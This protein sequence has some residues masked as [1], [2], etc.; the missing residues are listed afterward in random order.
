MSLRRGMPSRLAVAGALGT[1]AALAATVIA[2][3]A[4]GLTAGPRGDGTGV[5]P[6]GWIVDPA[7]TQVQVGGRPYGL[8]LSPDGGR[9]LLSNDGQGTQSLMAVDTAA[10]SVA[11]TLPYSS[12][13]ALYLGVVYAPDGKRAY[14]SAGGN[15]KVRTYQVAADG[16]LTETAA[17]ALPAGSYPGGLATSADGKRLYVAN[18]LGESLAIVDTATGTVASTTPVGHNP[19][20]VALSKDGTRAYV[21]NWG[22]NTVSAA[23]AV[24]GASLGQVTVGTHP[25]A[26]AVNPVSGELYVANS[27]GDSISVVDTASGA[28]TKTIDLAP[29]PNA[30][31]GT[32]PDALAVAPNGKTLYVANAGDNDVAVVDLDAGTVAGLIPVGWYP[33]GLAV[34]KD[35]SQLY[36]T[37]GKGLGAGPNPNGPTPYHG[38]SEDQYSGSMITGTLSFVDVP[39]NAGQL[40]KLTEQVIRNDDLCQGAN[41]RGTDAGTSVIPRR[42]GE[43]SPIKHV[44]YVIKENRTYD[45]EFGSLGKGNGDPTLDLFG[46]DSAPNA[47]ALQRRFVTLDNLYASSE[48]SADGW[49]W[50]TEATA[51][52]YDQKNWPANYSGRGRG[53]DFEGTNLATAAS[54]DPNNSYIWDRLARAGISFRNYGFWDTGTIPASVSPLEPE[55]AATTDTQYPGY[56]L[57]ITDQTRIA[58]WLKEFHGYETAG[59]LPAVQFVRLPNDHTAGTTPGRPTPKAMVADN[60]LA[61]GKLV[62]AVSHSKFWATTA[63]F[64]IEDDAQNGPD[65]VDAHRTIAQVISPYSQTGRVDSTFYSTVSMLRTME[66][67]VGL[68]PLTQFDAAATPMIDSFANKP[69]LTPYSAITPSQSLTETNGANAVMAAASARMSFGN[70]DQAPEGQLNEAI[71]KSVKGANSPMPKP[72]HTLGAVDTDD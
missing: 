56:N 6:N 22:G 10:K 60:D 7:G 72:K 4:G 66:L 52:T 28:V 16:S 58:E 44:I 26:L 15:N 65:H 47:R 54:K 20:T 1:L 19:Y 42:V 34:S 49:S 39:A 59:S 23:N 29:Y 41:V 12:P 27:D 24:T 51:N 32:S 43:P 57:T 46:D 3:A 69:D 40:Q 37:N 31:V 14:A 21:S 55:L 38:S 68:P 64:V 67:I 9:L 13:Q 62:D 35:G 5:T 71:W 25:S 18:D 53:Y 30:P 50:S 2:V 11:Q 48:V 63:I 36:V 33:T 17:I 8:A 45:Q 70:A 61:L